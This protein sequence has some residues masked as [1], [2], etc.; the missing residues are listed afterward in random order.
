MYYI[1]A[2]K[3][4]KLKPPYILVAGVFSDL[5]EE[6]RCYIH[7]S[8]CEAVL[9]MSAEQCLNIMNGNADTTGESKLATK[10]GFC[11]QFTILQG[12]CTVETMSRILEEN[13][14]EFFNIVV[15]YTP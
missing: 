7:T 9:G 14:V 8:I 1:L 10:H 5:V 4:F 3:G 2:I 6:Y 11:S 12:V 13:E 15:K